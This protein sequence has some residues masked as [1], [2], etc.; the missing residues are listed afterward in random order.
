MVFVTVPAKQSDYSPHRFSVSL[1]SLSILQASLAHA[2]EEVAMQKKIPPH[3]NIVKLVDIE[4]QHDK[5]GISVINILME[6]MSGEYL[7]PGATTLLNTLFTHN[8]DP[9]LP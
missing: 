9:G 5:K 1:A 3:E 2:I 7:H 4:M 6:N 8:L